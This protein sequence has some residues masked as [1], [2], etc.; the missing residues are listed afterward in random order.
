MELSEFVA[1]SLS[2][3]I[4]GIETAQKGNGGDNINARHSS[5]DP[6]GDYLNT[7]FGVFTTVHFDVAVSAESSIGGEGG[8]QVFSVGAKT[9]GQK[10]S[11][12]QSKISFTVPIRLPSGDSADVERARER[13][14][15]RFEEAKAKFTR[16]RGPGG[17]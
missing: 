13:A 4:A 1:K 11:A 16:R 9:T 17:A 15:Q 2:S 5:K 12:Y 7:E 6:N 14:R 8:I 3:I 10:Q